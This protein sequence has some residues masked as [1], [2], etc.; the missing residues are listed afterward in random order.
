MANNSEQEV[1]RQVVQ[2]YI[3]GSHAGDVDLLKRIFHPKALMS[4]YLMGDLGIGGPEPFFDA[5]ANNPSAK[6]S[7]APYSAEI[8]SVE[9]AGS[10]ACATLVEKGFLGLDF[11]DFF[12]LIKENDKWSIIAKTFHQG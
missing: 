9:V 12:H 7:G 5:V 8:T 11:I 10:A 2:Q 3:D 1:V 4:G 6:E